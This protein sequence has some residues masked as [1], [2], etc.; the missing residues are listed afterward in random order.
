MNAETGQVSYERQR[1]LILRRGSSLRHSFEMGV[2]LLAMLA[3]AVASPAAEADSEGAGGF[4]SVRCTADQTG[5]FHDYPG[6][7]EAYEPAL[8]NPQQFNL[9]ENVVFM[10]NL[11]ERVGHV[12]LYLT[13]TR[14]IPQESGESV[15]DTTEL[16]CREVRGADGSFGFSCVNLPPSEML[17]INGETLRFTR[18]AVGGWTFTGAEGERNGDSIFV[19]YGQCEPMNEPA[20]EPS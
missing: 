6:G 16:E 9:E 4:P 7:E 15:T 3:Y 1:A 2:S 14:Q 17:L 8:F 20:N 5:G 10:L 12:D 13:L 19:E 11:T 18:T